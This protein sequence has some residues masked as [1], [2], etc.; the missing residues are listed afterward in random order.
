MQY[1]ISYDIAAILVLIVLAGGMNTVLYTDTRGA[2]LVRLYVYCVFIS[3][4]I[5]VL[6]AYTISYGHLIPDPVNVLLNT[7][8]QVSSIA[9]VAVGV[10]T[11]FSYYPRIRNRDLVANHILVALLALLITVNLFTGVVFYFDAGRYIHGPLYFMAYIMS[12]LVIIHAFFVVLAN[13]A[14][15]PAVTSTIVMFFLAIPII[16]SIVQMFHPDT[17]LNAFGEAFA[18]IIMLFA[19]E[20]PDY[21]KLMKTMNELEIA[22]EEANIANRAKSDFL[23]SMSHEIRTPIN[24]ILGMDTMILRD[25]RDDQIAEY[26]ENIRISGN[27]LLSIINDILDLSK[28]ESG[29][30]ELASES[31]ELFSILSDCYQMNRMR[32]LEKGL[33][34]VIENDPDMPSM[35]LGDEVRIRQIV[36]NLIS[37]GIKYTREGFVKAGVICST[38]EDPEETL[39]DA[40]YSMLEIRVSDS[41]IGIKEED[42]GRLFMTFSRLEEERNRNIEGTGLGLHITRQIVTAMKGTIDVKSE[43]GKGS[44]FTVRIPQKIMDKSPMGDFSQRLKD[45]IH[46]VKSSTDIISAPGK[47]VLVVD[48]VK[49]NIL[50]FAGLLKGSGMEIDTALSGPEAIEKT[51]EKKYDII[52]MDH[53]MPDMDGVETLHRIKEDASGPNADTPVIVLTANAIVG[54]RPMYMEEGFDNYLTKPV[55]QNILLK[56]INET[57]YPSVTDT[58]QKDQGTK[59][60][61]GS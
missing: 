15:R 23:A 59:T 57:L 13:R 51:K 8:Y 60:E 17:L 1:N 33:D 26:A 4:L 14:Y 38:I 9:C 56:V 36:N 35:Y 47:K 28:I 40:G 48:D 52:F 39:G 45:R 44:V 32:A 34:F 18:A 7:L 49:M 6:T 46:V 53:L 16:F 3:A 37:N 54:V 43:Y 31:Y 24:G 5:D 29:K 21:R 27:A 11:V 61:S 55:E 42:L 22:K 19:L 2:G 10:R 12:F 30:M 20:T 41:G 25:C 50:V 58:S